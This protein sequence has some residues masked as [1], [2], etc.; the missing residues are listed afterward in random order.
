MPNFLRSK[1]LQ[2]RV[3]NTKLKVFK[4]LNLAKICHSGK[5]KKH[6]TDMEM[7]TGLA[8]D[9][10]MRQQHQIVENIKD[11]GRTLLAEQKKEPLLWTCDTI[12][13]LENGI[14]NL[15]VMLSLSFVGPFKIQGE[16]KKTI[17]SVDSANFKFIAFELNIV[18]FPEDETFSIL[19]IG[20]WF[21]LRVQRISSDLH[22]DGLILRQTYTANYTYSISFKNH[23]PE[24]DQRDDWT[25][26]LICSSNVW[27]KE[28]LN[29]AQNC[30]VTNQMTLM[31]N[32]NLEKLKRLGCQSLKP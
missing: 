10:I 11:N 3:N 2:L 6:I 22:C 27:Q 19:R 21:D 18:V 26:P 7:T 12:K 23:H 30:F 25:K 17:G 24:I 5:V 15:S 1:K 4:P 20:S 14:P 31:N 16:M 32:I 28:F 8:I 9:E 29:F 13:K